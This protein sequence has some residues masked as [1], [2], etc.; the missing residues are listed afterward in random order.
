MKLISF[1]LSGRYGH[2]LRAEGGA[3]ALSYPVPPRTVILGIMGAVLGLEKD[4]PQQVLEPAQ[5]AL[6]GRLPQTHWHK[7]KLRKDPPAPLPPVIKKKQK[8]TATDEKPSLIWQEWLFMPDYTVWVSIPDPF[9]TELEQR[10]VRRKWH[11]QPCLGLSEMAADLTFLKTDE[12]LPLPEGFYTVNS[13]FPQNDVEELDMD[14]VFEDELAVRILRMPRSVTPDR[15][16]AHAAYVMERDA[17][18]I[19]VKTDKAFKA[20]NE[21]LIFL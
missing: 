20:G 1:R 11:F 8:G 4:R 5:I 21:V 6:R 9:L 2:F 15:V 12:A 7:A 14:K 17:R 18:P 3:G 13:I 16:F 19:P 10:L